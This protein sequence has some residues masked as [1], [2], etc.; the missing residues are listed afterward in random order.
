MAEQIAP[1]DFYTGLVA[2]LYAHLRAETFDPEP[3]ARFIQRSGEPALEL[4]CGDGD[5]MLALRAMGLDVTGVDSSL[6]MLNRLEAA[7]ARQGLEATVHHA[8]FEAMDIGRQFR[9]IYFA[10]ATFNLLPD[11]A[12]AQVTLERIAAHLHPEGSV[13]VPLFT[14]QVAAESAQG[15]VTQHT[16]AGGDTMQVTVLDIVRDEMARNQTTTLRYERTQ[17]GEHDTVEREWLLH[18]YEQ[19]Q[20]MAMADQAGL[21]TL[22]VR[23]ASGQA[24]TVHDTAC[25]FILGHKQPDQ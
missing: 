1:A 5:P 2:E 4:G 25:T 21:Q 15:K 22:S 24:V 11:D 16:T 23:G 14:P 8:T 10:G 6:D 3:F 18:W 17:D 12:A 13:L 20:F 7:A 9:S 19:E